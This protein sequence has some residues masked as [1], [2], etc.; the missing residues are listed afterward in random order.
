MGVPI[1]TGYTV[2]E[3]R[4]T[5]YLEGAT[6]WKL[7]EKWQ[8]IQGSEIDLDVDVICISVGLS[9]LSELLWQ[10]GC[11]M[12]F[13]GE[14]GGYVPV[15]NE[16]MET[17]VKGIF[18][19]GDVG[20]VEEASSAMVEGYLAGLSAAKYL[21]HVSFDMKQK[22]E[23]YLNQLN[24]LRSGPV[25]GKTRAGILKILNVNEVAAGME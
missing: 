20:G 7:D 22:R 14:L 2:K 19:G 18:I 10:A 3:A 4:G 15:R 9:P 8:P 12:K 21:G 11:D 17:S 16:D 25:G 24:A 6:I 1:L 13:V 5:E 23:D